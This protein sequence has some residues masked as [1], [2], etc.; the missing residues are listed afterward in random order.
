MPLRNIF[1]KYVL[2]SCQST[3]AT[4]SLLTFGSSSA[5]YHILSGVLL[6]GGLYGPWYS[7]KVLEGTQRANP[8][9]LTAC[10]GVWLVSLD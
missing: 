7:K 1:K 5:H 3:D 10:A 4:C 9:F 2:V 6:A 8:Q